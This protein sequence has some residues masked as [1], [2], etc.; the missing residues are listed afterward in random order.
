[1]L[2]SARGNYWGFREVGTSPHTSRALEFHSPEG[3]AFTIYVP[4]CSALV[5]DGGIQYQPFRI[6]RVQGN[7]D[8]FYERSEGTTR[9]FRKHHTL[10]EQ[11]E[12]IR[13]ELDVRV[14]GRSVEW[15]EPK[16]GS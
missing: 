8:F 5:H 2:D 15:R 1:M 10:S 9:V 13:I 16:P 3:E 4:P 6:T 14:N 11:T 12:V 7:R